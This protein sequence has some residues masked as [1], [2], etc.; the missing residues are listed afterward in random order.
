MSHRMNTG[1]LELTHSALLSIE[2]VII[3]APGTICRYQI[4][5]GNDKQKMYPFKVIKKG[6]LVRPILEVIDYNLIY[7]SNTLK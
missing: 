7:L 6:Y 5:Y 3:A 4:K 1:E 2:E